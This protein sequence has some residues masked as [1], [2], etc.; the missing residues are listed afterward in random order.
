MKTF[1]K[2]CL[3]L[4]FTGIG[5]GIILLIPVFANGFTMRD[6]S[7]Y[8]FEESFEDV[9]SLDISIDFGYVTIIRGDEFRVEADHLLDR[10]DFT[11]EAENGVL[12]INHEVDDK[13]NFFDFNIPSVYVFGDYFEP[14]I[15]IMI[16]EDFVADDIYLELNAGR[17]EVDDLRSKTGSFN[18]SA[19]EIVINHL[20][21]SG[22]SAYR[23]G[24]G[25]MKLE[26]ID[27][28]DI[29]VDCGIG[30]IDIE[31]RLTGDNYISCDIG[32]VR[33]ELEGDKEDYS[34]EADIKLGNAVINGDSYN[35]ARYNQKS[36]G[37]EAGS[38]T[39]DCG[40]GNI[41][42]DIK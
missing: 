9:E 7:T 36:E 22:E 29:T 4:G 17:M 12:T 5:I 10:I 20:V 26:Q 33:L 1:I 14:E 28:K 11:A 38:F 19:G 8:S 13:I 32:R 37:E 27:A 21:L 30:Y 31:G 35:N 34:Y 24:T 18:V 23:V 3:V 41:T 25:H 15:T 16:P 6:I 39:M 2:V 40:I 42:L